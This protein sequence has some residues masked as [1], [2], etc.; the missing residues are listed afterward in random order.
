MCTNYFRK[1]RPQ[2]N[3][4]HKLY[5][6]MCEGVRIRQCM[7]YIFVKIGNAI[8]FK[9]NTYI[10]TKTI[11]KAR[12][13]YIMTK[14]F[15]KYFLSQLVCNI[16]VTNQFIWLTMHYIYVML[17]LHSIITF[18]AAKAIKISSST[19]LILHRKICEV[20]RINVL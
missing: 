8:V 13:I 10:S 16:F 5:R 2:S 20:V 19:N 7:F 9:A 14:P 3:Q 17:Q 15:F 11:K 1:Y 18:N 12:T 4:K 6:Q